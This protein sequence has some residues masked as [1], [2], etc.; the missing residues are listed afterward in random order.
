MKT[1]QELK[2]L[3]FRL[4]RERIASGLKQT[5]LAARAAL[6]FHTVAAAERG[7]PVTTETLARILASLGYEG[8]LANLLPE[9]QLSPLDLRKLKGKERERVR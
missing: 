4:K 2:E 5:D 8:H 9:P 7:Q 1:N 6:S 3:G